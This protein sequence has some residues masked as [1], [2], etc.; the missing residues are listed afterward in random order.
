[1]CV[2]CYLQVL[3]ERFS[4]MCKDVARLTQD[5]M[6]YAAEVAGYEECLACRYE[7]HSTYDSAV[8]LETLLNEFK[9]EV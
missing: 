3:G 4:E 2:C 6:A 9:E 1:M 8:A 5:N 7:L